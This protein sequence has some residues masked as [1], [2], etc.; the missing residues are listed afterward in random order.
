MCSELLPLLSP[1]LSPFELLQDLN[2][3]W[4]EQPP[5]HTHTGQPLC[6]QGAL[7][8]VAGSAL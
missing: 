4:T 8:L 5:P 2:W 6:T 7:T 3:T 1:F